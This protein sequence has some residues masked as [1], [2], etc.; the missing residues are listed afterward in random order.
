[1]VECPLL[2]SRPPGSR[3]GPEA[4][5]R[6][7]R[8]RSCPVVRRH[9][10]A[11]VFQGLGII[12]KGHLVEADRAGLVG[13]YIGQTALKTEGEVRSARRSERERAFARR[14]GPPIVCWF[15]VL[16]SDC[17]FTRRRHRTSRT[18]ASRRRSHSAR[19]RPWR[20][21]RTVY[22]SILAVAIAIVA[23]LAAE[24]LTHLIGLAT[25]L[26]FYGRFD[27]ELVS[28]AGGHRHSATLLLIP[29]LGAIVIGIMARF[30]SAA[31]RGP[32]GRRR[33]WRFSS[34]SKPGT[35]QNGD[36]RRWGISVRSRTKS[37]GRQP[38]SFFHLR[39]HQ[40]GASS[41]VD[42]AL[43]DLRATIKE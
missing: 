41:P 38:R 5:V 3:F 32:R 29:I 43:L 42:Q 2:V 37:I 40:I 23:S 33:A 14:R 36:T 4:P 12:T 26:A 31:I 22:V 34:T 6:P 21:D 13:G 24:L 15:Y 18:T 16:A 17:A 30:G 9:R 19:L 25:N 8:R 20:D 35:I 1:M 28:P 39:V 27:F 10:L 7:D 11:Q